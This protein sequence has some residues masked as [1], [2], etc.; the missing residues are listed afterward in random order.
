MELRTWV[1]EHKKG[2]TALAVVAV[3]GIGAAGVGV[4]GYVPSAEEK[5]KTETVQSGKKEE[6]KD[7]FSSVKGIRDLYVEQNAKEIDW[8]KG[9]SFDNGIKVSVDDA[10]VDVSKPGKYELC[11]TASIK[12][13]KDAVQTKKVTVT[14]VNNKE[15]QKLADEG[16]TV[17]MSKNQVKAV[18][19]KQEAVK[20]E[21]K[22]QEPKQEKITTAKA[23]QKEEL[24]QQTVQEETKVQEELPQPEQENNSSVNK[25]ESDQSPAPQPEK[26][27]QPEKKPVWHDPVYEKKWVVD[28]AAWDE[29]IS[30][31]IY[32]MVEKSICNGCLADITGN[33]WG[34][35]DAALDAGNFNCGGYHSEWVQEQTGTN[36]Y[37]V[38]HDEVGHWE[39]VLVQEGYWE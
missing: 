26:P 12:E 11:Y 34:H 27:S 6:E 19:K 31:P 8:M 1:K 5:V 7:L 22:K 29:T 32:E 18:T 36:T 33:P 14:V 30:E 35:I 21:E 13:K 17:W 25:Q 4:A 3:L 38:H 16:K 39:E 9:I 37:T 2:A 15:A 20:K 24:K 10:D 28:Q 23:E